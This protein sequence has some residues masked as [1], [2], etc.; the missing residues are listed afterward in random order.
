MAG[1]QI[2]SLALKWFFFATGGYP[3]Y[4]GFFNVFMKQLGLS[5]QQIGLT[6]LFGVQSAFVPFLLYVA[7]KYRLRYLTVWMVTIIAVVTCL[8]VVLP[9]VVS[10][11][12]CFA[13]NTTLNYSGKS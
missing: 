1:D 9:I 6:N 10:L 13:M 12:S 4:A 5:S 2:K 11:P 8:L 7:D 3:C